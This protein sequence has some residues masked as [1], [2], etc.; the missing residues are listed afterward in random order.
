MNSQNLISL[1]QQVNALILHV[2]NPSSSP[3]EWCNFPVN[4]IKDVSGC[5]VFIVAG[6]PAWQCRGAGARVR[7]ECGFGEVGCRLVNSAGAFG[8]AASPRGSR[9]PR[10]GARH[11]QHR[12]V[13]CLRLVRGSE[14]LGQQGWY[15]LVSISPGI[16][17]ANHIQAFAPRGWRTKVNVW[18]YFFL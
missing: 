11:H 8:G 14:G 2:N 18:I 17:M 9:A 1:N 15:L 10:A 12:V 6:F 13:P 3:T 4:Q 5:E 7:L 16:Y